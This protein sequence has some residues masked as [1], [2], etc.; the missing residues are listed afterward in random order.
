MEY[1]MTDPTRQ[2]PSPRLRS[3]SLYEDGRRESIIVKRLSNTDMM[4]WVDLGFDKQ[5]LV[6][7]SVEMLGRD[8]GPPPRNQ[9]GSTPSPRTPPSPSSSAPSRST[10]PR[11]KKKSWPRSWRTSNRG[12]R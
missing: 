6:F 2:T 3:K 4:K 5:F 11:S 8:G 10:I 7:R 12:C 1:N 9:T